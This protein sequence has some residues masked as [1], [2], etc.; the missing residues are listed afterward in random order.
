MLT[1][2]NISFL[3]YLIQERHCLTL[4]TK[5]LSTMHFNTSFFIFVSAT[6]WQNTHFP[7]IIT[8]LAWQTI[9]PQHKVSLLNKFSE[10]MVTVGQQ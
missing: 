2:K 1:R 5:H 6:D 10:R 9:S 4:N 8:S 3:Y 7:R